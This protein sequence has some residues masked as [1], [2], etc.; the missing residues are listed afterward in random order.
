MSGA[1]GATQ[2]LARK[3]KSMILPPIACQSS[4]HNPK[5]SDDER[6]EFNDN[7]LPAVSP[8]SLSGR[9][10][11]RAKVYPRLQTLSQ[12]VERHVEAMRADDFVSRS[13][14]RWQSFVT[15]PRGSDGTDADRAFIIT[16]QSAALVIQCYWRRYAAEIVLNRKLRQL[17]ER[18][19]TVAA[20]V[21]LRIPLLT[22][23]DHEISQNP[24]HLCV[25]LPAL[26]RVFGQGIYYTLAAATIT[27][28]LRFRCTRVSAAF[29]RRP[30]VIFKAIDIPVAMTLR[31]AGRLRRC[32]AT[33]AVIVLQNASRSF[34]ARQLTTK[35]RLERR[36]RVAVIRLQCFFR[37][38]AARQ[39]AHQ[40]RRRRATI[41]IQCWW[42]CFTARLQATRQRI[43]RMAQT[44]CHKILSSASVQV[45]HLIYERAAILIQK[46]YRS[47]RARAWCRHLCSE[48]QK[49]SWQKNPNKGLALFDRRQY[50]KAALY[51]EACKLQGGFINV[52]SFIDSI[53]SSSQDK[54]AA[55]ERRERNCYRLSLNSFSSF[56]ESTTNLTHTESAIN[57]NI[58]L[59]LE[60]WHAY[61][62]SH[63]FSYEANGE[64]INLR[65]ASD[66]FRVC[67]RI[68]EAIN[69]RL[70]SLQL[71]ISE[72]SLLQSFF[73]HCKYHLIL[74]LFRLGEQKAWD[75]VLGYFHQIVNECLTGTFTSRQKNELHLVVSMIY[76]DRGDLASCYRL[77]QEIKQQE[78]SLELPVS[79]TIAVLQLRQAQLNPRGSSIDT[80]HQLEPVNLLHRC[81]QIIELLPGVGFYHGELDRSIAISL[82]ESEPIGSYLLHRD[83]DCKPGT[84]STSCLGTN[85]LLLQ[86]RLPDRVACV[87][88]DHQENGTYF[89]RK[90]QNHPSHFSVHELI[91]SLPAS[92]GVKIERGLRKNFIAPVLHTKLQCLQ[93]TELEARIQVKVEMLNWVAWLSRVNESSTESRGYM[94]KQCNE[95]WSSVCLEVARELECREAWLFSALVAREILT[96][97]KSRYKRACANYILAR[98]LAQVHRNHDTRRHIELAH[99][100]A[101]FKMCKVKPGFS[102]G[103]KTMI[104]VERAGGLRSRMHRHIAEPFDIQLDRICK[105]ERMCLKAWR[106]NS[107]S[108][109]LR[110]DAFSESVLLQ[111][112]QDEM[113]AEC[114][115]VFFL[116]SVARAHVSAYLL[117]GKWYDEMHLFYAL[118]CIARLVNMYDR[119]N[120]TPIPQTILTATLTKL[121][122]HIYDASRLP[123]TRHDVNHFRLSSVLLS[124]RN[125]PFVLCFEIMEVIYRL[126]GYHIAHFSTVDLI[127][128]YQSL[129]SRIR[130][131]KP[132]TVMYSAYEELFL[133]RLAFLHASNV[134]DTID[135]TTHLESAVGCINEIVVLR[136]ERSSMQ[137]ASS[138][139]FKNRRSSSTSG[140]K[141]ITWPSVIRV[142]IGLSDAEIIFIRGFLIEIRENMISLPETGRKSWKSYQPLH[143]ELIE[144]VAA[145]QQEKNA[146]QGYRSRT[147][148]RVDRLRGLRVYIG[149]TKNIKLHN[150]L[151]SKPYISIWCEGTT[152]VTKS[153]P[154]WTD[155]TPSWDEFIEFDVKSSHARIVISLMDRS[156][157][158]SFG[159]DLLLGQ[160]TIFMRELL[161]QESSVVDGKF[162]ELMNPADANKNNANEESEYSKLFMNFEVILAANVSSTGQRKF[163]HTRCGTF[164]MEEV[165]KNLHG[166][167]RTFV[168][169]RWI[170]SQFAHFFKREHEH[171]VA[172]WFFHKAFAMS[173]GNLEPPETETDD[174]DEV[175]A[176]VQDLTGLCI[177]L[178]ATMCNTDWEEYGRPLLSQATD[179]LSQ[180]EGWDSFEAANNGPLQKEI[181]TVRALHELSRQSPFQRAIAERV[182]ASSQWI[183]VPQN[184]SMSR[185]ATG[186]RTPKSP[187]MYYF[188][189]D[190]GQATL[191]ATYAVS[192]ITSAHKS[193]LPP[194]E[195]ESEDAII[196]TCDGVYSWPSKGVIVMNDAMKRRIALCQ[197]QV[198]RDP[199]NWIAVFNSRRQ[200]MQ[201]FSKTTPT[202]WAEGQRRQVK[203]STYVLHANDHTLYYV[204]VI[205]DAFRK[206]VTKRKRNRLVYGIFRCAFWAARELTACRKRMFERSE[207]VRKSSLNCFVIVVEKGRY[208]RVGDLISSDP[209]TLLTIK[210]PAGEIVATGKTTVRRNTRNPRWNEEF[211]FPYEY[212]AHQELLQSGL[213][214]NLLKE[215]CVSFVVLDHD[216]FTSDRENDDDADLEQLPTKDFLGQAV[217]AI[218]SFDHGRKM[219]SELELFGPEDDDEF[220][221]Q[222]T[223]LASKGRGTLT[224][225]MQ[226][227]HQSAPGWPSHITPGK[228]HSV[229]TPKRTETPQKPSLPEGLAEE[230]ESVHNRL[231]IVASQASELM[232]STLDPLSRLFKRMKLAQSAGRTAE[233]AKVH[234]QRVIVIATTQL[235][236]KFLSVQQAMQQL[237]SLLTL[238][239]EHLAAPINTYISDAFNP[240]DGEAAVAGLKE[241]LLA[242][243]IPESCSST[244]A[245]V[246]SKPNDHAHPPGYNN[247]QHHLGAVVV[248]STELEEWTL[249][250][251]TW[252]QRVTQA[253]RL[254]FSNGSNVWPEPI[255][256]SMTKQLYQQLSAI[257][258]AFQPAPSTVEPSQLCST[259]LEGGSLKESNKAKATASMAKRKER[260]ERE[261]KK[262]ARQR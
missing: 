195:Y 99:L 240:I 27:W 110:G 200:E 250:L 3:K 131:S 89:V 255:D 25:T 171:T 94:A 133:L 172:S 253:M 61:S 205:Q 93:P 239:L 216:I 67:M 115:D 49:R 50:G 221:D 13:E 226:W 55:V 98:T 84:P 64:L 256:G 82:L 59:Y 23:V 1:N 132:R 188:N 246:A 232:V 260:I 176:R 92:A 129:Y 130:G 16:R 38:Y 173:P 257:V 142:P 135:S 32:I 234:E 117:T 91:A 76:F 104:A 119:K 105:L 65:R 204:L 124:W 39:L 228:R 75:E 259:E 10:P 47:S 18:Q 56:T 136:K 203:P 180:V 235:Y 57:D 6:C 213:K 168:S 156:G 45:A 35:L 217:V 166:D 198:M 86:V 183:A 41:R 225:S 199:L 40:V 107:L 224:I 26:S 222:P 53:A 100:E 261:K 151:H 58:A 262:K 185:P 194:L 60:F 254:Y 153:Q 5:L 22:Y 54:A 102:F 208:L 210:N 138:L 164:D 230:I 128:A 19:E 244:A 223:S 108:S 249:R 152:L 121:S 4:P 147:D 139:L 209:Y 163:K 14:Q 186:H 51:L 134:S 30:P 118:D 184:D 123:R 150:M 7:N 62:V 116:R 114:D 101:G 231:Q 165:N 140:M 170:W 83:S 167:L 220:N 158:Y 187:V 17:W 248:L 189:Q 103:L 215:A 162:Y 191:G 177:C 212:T 31:L 218:S 36:K 207:D 193:N 97:S 127:D 74:C 52:D 143:Q 214:T 149:A 122:T 29:L 44:V 68:H 211:C 33:R 42:R 247:L 11:R 146:A 113:Y 88:I 233:E 154:A 66:G 78:A 81:Y 63:F 243:S 87:A 141:R 238:V 43:S 201:F 175:R 237:A 169:S 197:R 111:R 69:V 252:D 174:V 159:K 202:A 96:W 227:I 181:A 190:T 12:L 48:S 125:L 236:P 144:I 70:E 24:T 15:Q 229:V 112:I 155:L 71:H 109:S 258:Q 137:L 157:R 95:S 90:L 46:S 8:I 251:H 28:W 219:T 206:Y 37:M 72:E 241:L 21:T 161:E 182:P 79:F 85:T 120:E 9:S 179:A 196:S 20:W 73:F 126:S 2:G 106:Y 242:P 80:L 192:S 178:R 160:T 34:I 245:L 145:T 148:S 77:L